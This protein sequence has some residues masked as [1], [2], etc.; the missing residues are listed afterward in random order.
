MNTAD[1]VLSPSYFHFQQY[2]VL[3][4]LMHFRSPIIYLL[5]PPPQEMIAVVSSSSSPILQAS[6]SIPRQPYVL[7]S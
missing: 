7:F 1:S 6:F 3:H 5:L 4:A 2:Q